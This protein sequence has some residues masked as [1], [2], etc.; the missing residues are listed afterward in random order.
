MLGVAQGVI[1]RAAGS[2]SESVLFSLFILGPSA[3]QSPTR[4]RI[5]TSMGE[6]TGLGD[7]M[8]ESESHTLVQC[9]HALLL[10]SSGPRLPYQPNG[11]LTEPPPWA[12]WGIQC[13]GA[14]GKWQLSWGAL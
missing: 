13:P 2:L 8:S 3:V 9:P 6:G 12:A 14:R 7:G 5:L 1:L 10:L 4:R 11:A